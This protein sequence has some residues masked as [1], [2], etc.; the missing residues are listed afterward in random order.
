MFPF[1]SH[2]DECRPDGRTLNPTSIIFS[3]LPFLLTFLAVSAI[4]Q[5]KLLPVF[6][7]DKGLKDRGFGSKNGPSIAGSRPSIKR[8]SALTFSVTIALA[9]VLAE[10]VLCE[11]SNSINPVVRGLA[12]RVT[13]FFLLFVLIVA[14]PSLEIQSIISAAGYEYTGK[15]KGRLRLAW[16]FQITTFASWLFVFWWCGSQM[17]GKPPTTPTK[18]SLSEACLERVGVIGITFMALLSGFAATSSPWQNFL[19]HP[20]PVTEADIAR[21]EAGMAATNDMLSAKL[22]RLRAFERKLTDRPSESYFQKALGTLRP[23]ADASELKTLELEVKGLETMGL[24]LSTA[25]SLL[26]NQHAQQ[27]R[28]RTTTG[29]LRL[30]ASYAFSLFCLYRIFTTAL[31]AL[32]RHLLSPTAT[33]SSD[34]VTNILALLAKHYDPTLDQPT[35]SRQISLLLS[36]LILAASFSSVLQTLSLFSRFLPSLLKTIQANLA[37]VVAQ[38]CATYVIAAALMLRGMIPGEVMGSGY[39]GLGGG[40]MGWVDG[41]FEILF[42]SGVGVTTVGIWLGRKLGA[43]DEEWDDGD[44]ESGKRS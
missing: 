25:H 9:A 12:L 30:S 17:L 8:L 18:Q 35:Y 2:C 42:L 31:S 38:L 16:V 41:W 1:G 39:K 32:R 3:S 40:Q 23:N 36:F 27:Q 24:S 29:R 44:V 20:R 10:L 28:S 11:I 22:S 5:Q 19:H 14:I 26:L 33:P 34:P 43:D 15:N 37:L 21:K 7:A 4:V 6:S 13:V